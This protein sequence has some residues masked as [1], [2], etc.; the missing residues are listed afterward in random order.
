MFLLLKGHSLLLLLTPLDMKCLSYRRILLL[1]C[2]LRLTSS[3]PTTT[4]TAK[5][6]LHGV[7]GSSFWCLQE[8]QQL[9]PNLKETLGKALPNITAAFAT[10]APCSH[11]TSLR[12][13]QLLASY[14]YDHSTAQMPLPVS[15]NESLS[16]P[17]SLL[18]HSSHFCPPQ[19]PHAIISLSLDTRDAS[20]VTSQPGRLVELLQGQR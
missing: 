12:L 19:T 4:S 13:A 18:Q 11:K 2:L 15:I 10:Q 14:T 17:A 6:P 16:P 3:T 8:C 7:L 1:Y 5:S 20:W 9:L